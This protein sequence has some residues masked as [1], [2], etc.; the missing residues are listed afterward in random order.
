MNELRPSSSNKLD[1]VEDVDLIVSLHQVNNVK[2]RAEQTASFRAVSTQEP[3]HT[4]TS[5]F[6]FTCVIPYGR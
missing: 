2:Q 6:T 4:I 3:C 1:C 5:P